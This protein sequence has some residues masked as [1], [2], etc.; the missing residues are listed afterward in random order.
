MFLA[1]RPSIISHIYLSV[2]HTV[3][4]ARSHAPLACGFWTPRTGTM[5]DLVCELRRIRL[6][7]TPVNKTQL[8]QDRRKYHPFA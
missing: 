6:P 5:Q 1:L 4:P 8:E 2:L 3:G 7:R